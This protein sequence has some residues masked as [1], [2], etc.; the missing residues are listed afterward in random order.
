MRTSIGWLRSWTVANEPSDDGADKRVI[1]IKLAVTANSAIALSVAALFGRQ[2]LL[3]LALRAPSGG[4]VLHSVPCYLLPPWGAKKKGD[5]CF[6]AQLAFDDALVATLA[7]LTH[8]V[9]LDIAL[10]NAAHEIELD[11]EQRDVLAFVAGGE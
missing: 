8:G 5:F 11:D 10:D 3:G 6:T 2:A 1:N 9:P 7:S 4:P